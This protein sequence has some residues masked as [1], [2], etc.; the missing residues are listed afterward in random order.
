MKK[1]IAF[2][3]LLVS[4]QVKGQQEGR[5]LA[6]SL[7]ASLPAAQNDTLKARLYNKIFFALSSVNVEEAQQ[8]ARVGLAHVHRMQW[9]KG[10]AVF[11]TNLGQGFTNAGHYDSSRYYF[12]QA[13]QTHA[14]AGDHYNMAVTYNSMG[15]AA[16]NIRADY[17]T[18]AHYY[19]KALQQ[20]EALKDSTLLS[21]TLDNISHIYLF[22]RNYPKALEFGRKALLIRERAGAPDDVALSLESIGKIYYSSGDTAGAK[23]NFQKAQSLYEGTGNMAGQASAWSSLSLV[24]GRNLRQILEARLKSKALWDE[25]NPV[26]PDAISNTGNL[27]LAYL[28]M[29]RYDTSSLV[30]YGGVAPANKG[31]L[32]RKAEEHLNTA[33]QLAGQTGDMDSKSFFTGAL[34]ELQ[35]YKGD[36][37]SAFYNYRMYKEMED[38]VYSQETKNKIAEAESQRSI[39]QKNT[40]LRINQ[41]ALS[42][43]RKTVWGLAA[44]IVLLGIIGF[45]LYRQSKMRQ[46]T[47]ETLVT[48]NNEL[49][50]ANKVKAKLFAILSHDLRAPVA[51]LIS[52]LHLRR[53]EPGML[54][55]AQSAQHEQ[56]LATSAEAL[57]ENMETVLLWS[58]GQLDQLLPNFEEV[59]T[60]DLFRYLGLQFQ[61]VEAGVLQFEG[62]V[63]DDLYTDEHCIKTI[64][65]NLTSN[66]LK[67]VA[68][69]SHP[70]ITWKAGKREGQPYLTITDNGAGLDPQLLLDDGARAASVGSVRSGLGL[71]IVKDLAKAIHCRI[72]FESVEEGT[73][74]GIVFPEKGA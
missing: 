72:V 67:A 8:Y 15:A 53:N 64:L 68:K 60:G 21:L 9:P 3:C 4:L 16:Q 44:G 25:V 10:I 2:I 28:D 49:D 23:A 59:T 20:A 61:Y 51:K 42:N 19:F 36:Y 38:S 27:G 66:S 22:Q 18:A 55:A 14:Q 56:Q 41:L 74:I 47:N 43:Q 52:F 71:S 45:L 62:P 5:A 29:V 48:L 54:T 40:E 37:K 58:K 13:L 33:I 7:I 31:L 1:L 26:H 12:D 17:T 46:Q 30:K 39:D 6:D 50:N 24:Y 69:Q 57:L 35:E 32:L 70:R 34:A 65:Y 63:D 73:C 11:Q